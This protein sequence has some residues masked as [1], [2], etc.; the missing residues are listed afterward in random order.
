MKPVL[1]ALLIVFAGFRVSAESD[2][3][4][5]LNSLLLQNGGREA[6][7]DEP[8]NY[9]I[10]EKMEAVVRGLSRTIDNQADLVS[11]NTVEDS[12]LGDMTEV[13]QRVREL[14]VQK[15]SGTLS[16]SD[17]DIIDSEISQLEDDVLDILKQ[18]E[19]NTIK[20]FAPLVD[21]PAMA[22]TITDPERQ[23]LEGVDSLLAFLSRQRTLVGTRARALEHSVSG[24]R[25]AHENSVAFQDQIL[26]MARL[27]LK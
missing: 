1:L 25:I 15:A 19:F 8:A 22:Q 21:D 4:N 12:M 16:S 3:L 20:L 13:E 9:A 14:L 7:P 6:L 11:Y 23:T 26:L 2:A 5:H 17:S 27:M 24:D 18:A 10:Y